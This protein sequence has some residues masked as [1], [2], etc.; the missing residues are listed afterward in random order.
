V[1]IAKLP[2]LFRKPPRAFKHSRYNEVE[3]TCRHPQA[4]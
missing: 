2:E 4:N 3:D 1:N